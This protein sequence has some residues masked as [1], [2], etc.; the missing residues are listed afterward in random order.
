MFSRI[1]QRAWD[2]CFLHPLQKRGVLQLSSFQISVL[3]PLPLEWLE[4]THYS[5]R[6]A[7]VVDLEDKL[8]VG[9]GSPH[10]PH[11]RHRVI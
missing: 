7:M 6:R 2:S 10:L 1:K 5:R 8:G 9:L 4:S 3:L 11:G